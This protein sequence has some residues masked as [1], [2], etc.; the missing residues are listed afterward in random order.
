MEAEVGDLYTA[1]C[2][3]IA[4]VAKKL[5]TQQCDESGARDPDRYDAEGKE[6]K[7]R[8]ET[9]KEVRDKLETIL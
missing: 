7:E 8:I 6:L 3:A 5:S 9:L 4:V 1:T 2:A